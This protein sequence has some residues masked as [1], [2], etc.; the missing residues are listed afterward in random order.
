MWNGKFCNQ[1]FFF[2]IW[3]RE[4]RPTLQFFFRRQNNCHFLSLHSQT[5][6]QS[7]WLAVGISPA[8]FTGLECFSLVSANTV[9][10]GPRRRMWSQLRGGHEFS[11]VLICKG[12][13]PCF[14]WFQEVSLRICELLE[15]TSFYLVPV[16]KPWGQ[17]DTPS[18][19]PCQVNPKPMSVRTEQKSAISTVHIV[20]RGWMVHS[21]YL[22]NT[23]VKISFHI[24]TFTSKY[25]AWMSKY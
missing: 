22:V 10:E 24:V 11:P 16:E 15:G 2:I 12:M 8:A 13:V 23:L 9:L 25:Q 1:K 6:V 14:A 18:A 4:L 5:S 17:C 20:Y 7:W 21:L 19:N 3:S